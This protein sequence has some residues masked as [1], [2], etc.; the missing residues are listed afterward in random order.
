MTRPDP[1][2]GDQQRVRSFL[3]IGG[4]V[5]LLAGLVLAAAGFI[6]FFSAFGTFQM[7]RNFWMA[8]VGLPLMGIGASML[9]AGYL[10]PASRYVAGEVTPTIHDTLGA[11]GVGPRRLTCPSC[12]GDNAPDARFC[13]DCG[14]P[15]RRTCPSCGGDNAPDARFCDDCGRELAAP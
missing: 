11:L 3:R 7:P 10:G 1:G 13:D 5:A 15:M 4:W 9:R 14:A 8:F 2:L 12:G 6:D